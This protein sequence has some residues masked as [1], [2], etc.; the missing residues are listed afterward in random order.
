MP[1]GVYSELN[2]GKLRLIGQVW[3]PS[4][5]ETAR[6]GEC[7]VEINRSIDVEGE[8]RDPESTEKALE[9]ADELSERVREQGGGEI[10]NSIRKEQEE[11][12]LMN[13]S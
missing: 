11:A 5:K 7:Y 12:K 8:L 1:I 4:R 10:I 3:H 6:H 13:E 9:V 2:E